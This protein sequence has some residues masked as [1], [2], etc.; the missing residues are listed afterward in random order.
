MR[1]RFFFVDW[2]LKTEKPMVLE[3]LSASAVGF[4]ANSLKNSKG[5]TQAAD[6]M[7]VAIWEWIRPIFLKEVEGD[8][9]LEM[10][11]AQPEDSEARASVQQTLVQYLQQH[12]QRASELKDLMQQAKSKYPERMGDVH[13]YGSVEKQVNNPNVQGDLNM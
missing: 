8:A 10:L 1:F 5:G 2:I 13:N 12:P 3:K 7:T 4:L 11:K 9:A 6:E